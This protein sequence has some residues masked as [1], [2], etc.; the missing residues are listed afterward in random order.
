M[1]PLSLRRF[2]P[3]L[4][5]LGSPALFA[6]P[7]SRPLAVSAPGHAGFSVI[8]PTDSGVT[9]ENQLSDLGGARNRTLYNGS[10]VA[11]GDFDG[12]G[13]P[14]IF[15]CGLESECALYRNLGGWKFEDV[16][17]SAG[18]TMPHEYS[19]GAVFSDVNGDGS[20]ELLVSVSGHGVV[21][22]M[23]DG[24]GHFSNATAAA[25]TESRFGAV[26]LALADVD[27]DGDLDLYVAN[28]RREDYR[29]QPE[30][31][32]IQVDG[33]LTIPEHLRDRFV[34]DEKGQVQEYGEPDQLYL[35]DG[36]GHFSPVSWTDG[37]FLDEDGKPL[38]RAP[39][40]W[41]LTAQF[42]DIDGDGAPDIYVCNDY[43]T[44]DRCWMN[45]GHGHFRA[46]DRLAIRSTSASSMGVDFADV[47]R[48]GNVDFMVV[49]ML[50][51]DHQR[52][53]MQMGAMKPTP[54]GLGLLD[55]RPQVMRNTFLHGRGDG[56]FA[57]MAYFSG[58]QASEWSWQPLFLDVDLD[59]YEDVLVT[60]G[61]SR[62]VQDADQSNEIKA[63][64]AEGKLI[65][66][67]GIKNFDLF[68]KDDV[69]TAE[70]LAMSKLRPRLET[71]VLAFKNM[72]DLHFEPRDW[73]TGALG[74]HHGIA[75][76]DF[77]GDGDLDLVVNNLGAPAS[78]FRND[79]PA[80]RVAVRLR[81]L[82]GNP[83]GIGARVTLLGG[84][85]PVQSGE[86]V[87]GGRY[88]SGSDTELCFAA[89]S[90]KS[91]S[92]EI[93]WRSGRRSVI[94]EVGLNT[95]V[96]ADEKEAQ[97]FTK[98]LPALAKPLF[99]DAS[100]RLGHTHHEN[101]FDDFAR[102]ALLPNRLSQLGPGITCTDLDGDGADDLLIASGAG[103]GTA[104]FLGDG[105]G[106]FKPFD[107]PL[108]SE[109]SPRDQTS[110]LAFSAKSDETSILAGVSN[111]E[112]GQATGTAVVGAP[113]IPTT[114]S[115]TGPLALADIDGDGQLDL[116]VGARSIPGKYP[117][118][119][120]SRLFLRKNGRLVPDE[121]NAP[122]FRDLGLVS[123]A[124]FSDL[125][126][127]GAPDLIVALEWGAVRIFM[128]DG[129]GRLTDATKQLGLADAL[130]WWNS[131]T[132]GD[133]D[134]DGRMDIIAGNW[135]RNSKYEHHYEPGHP[136]GIAWGDF[137]G[138]GITQVVESHFDD[139]MHKLVPERGLSCS[140][141]A[142]PF[143]RKITPTYTKFGAAGLED[144]YG[145][146]LKNAPSLQANTLDSMIFLN[147]GDHF[148]AHA[149]PMEAQ[150][151]PVFGIVAAD[152]DGD[153]KE[154][155]FLAQN[156]FSAQ[157]E[158]PRIDAGRGLLLLGDGKGAFKAASPRDSGI[159][160]DGDARGAATADFDKDGRPDLVVGQNAA[161][162]RLFLNTGGKPG[163]RVRLTD[164][165]GNATALG[166]QIGLVFADGS[167]GP[168][169]E[170]HGGSGYWSQDSSTVVLATPSAPTKLR[171]RWP[172][173]KET[174]TDIPS[175]A[176]EIAAPAPAR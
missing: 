30:L 127:D 129:H 46:I 141:L 14:D 89:G 18:V 78:L 165:E 91:M 103:A 81:G 143:I 142:M 125:N 45:D 170:I 76:A 21:V 4:L 31:H 79:S 133:F 169:R 15:F 124:V 23:N 126:A 10:G 90:A 28:N 75:A 42:R 174:V 159:T 158:T 26:T 171:V 63:L 145:D 8:A 175:G 47:D 64:K 148:E 33:K 3:L 157:V 137:N 29:D 87:A 71:A 9:F 173:G 44:P 39:L 108:L 2:I 113:E 25:G 155:L 176:K 138:D 86:M 85:V 83:T 20:P 6:A 135:G 35:N 77:D 16:T 116:F 7:E 32:L 88:L 99:T 117:A 11:V 68:K 22:F 38:A 17:R 94:P 102:Q 107:L 164:S 53:K 55:N 61:H 51:R 130:G 110:L 62:D 100:A 60:S 147:R 166:A 82:P 146:R 105:K 50:S 73:G 72:G 131:V 168:L 149:L 70:L 59:G 122:L 92:L 109:K 156:F 114:N 49:D 112:D 154:D 40:D 101:G 121:Q 34:L 84:A 167:A 54:L 144:I 27:G 98:S 162:T 52:R 119:A 96:I 104:A 152:F 163:L 111:F 93:L 139:A 118:P 12:D 41:G 58:L 67:A 115:A 24:K 69:H 140:S 136:L 19:R 120:T 132:T 95:L 65:E 128:N 43:W 172:G 37:A 36:K 1:S 160:V 57:E 134:G 80:P 153:G 150:L 161:A 123:G 13:K 66:K 48:D 97:P 106:G 56:T 5:A 151:A 74:V